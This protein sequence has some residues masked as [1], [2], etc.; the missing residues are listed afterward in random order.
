[1]AKIENSIPRRHSE[2]ERRKLCEPF[3]AGYRYD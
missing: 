2:E 3:D 1:M